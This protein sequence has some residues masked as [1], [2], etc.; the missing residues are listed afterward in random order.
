MKLKL[1]ILLVVAALSPSLH[2][3]QLG[4]VKTAFELIGPDHKIIIEAYDDPMVAGVTCFVSRAKTGGIGGALGIAEDKS[5]ASIACRQIGPI[6]FKGPVPRQEDVFTEK[7]S[8]LFKR[9]H[10][11]RIIDAK[12]SSL[13]YMTYSDKFVDGS[14]KNSITAVPVSGVTIP[15]R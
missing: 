3:E 12:R 6:V 9:L 10:I 8:F 13:I 7:M 1:S 4:E 15:T 14:P 5:E 11:V 2:A